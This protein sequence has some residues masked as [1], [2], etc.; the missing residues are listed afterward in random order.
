ML[1][2]IFLIIILRVFTV[3]GIRFLMAGSAFY[4]TEYLVH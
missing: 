3:L 2:I 1:Y 4:T